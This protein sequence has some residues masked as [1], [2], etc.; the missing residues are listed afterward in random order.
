MCWLRLFQLVSQ[1][2]KIL[3]PPANRIFW[4]IKLSSSGLENKIRI[5]LVY[6]KT[7][8]SQNLA[9]MQHNHHW[10]GWGHTSLALELH[11]QNEVYKL[12]KRNGLLSR[13]K[14]S[15][16]KN[17]YLGCILRVYQYYNTCSQILWGQSGKM[18]ILCT[19]LISWQSHIWGEC[20]KSLFQGRDYLAIK[21]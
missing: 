18:R 16:E 19:M 3:V 11:P 13:G 7:P 21:N 4:Q 2:V 17:E 20:M 9:A 12:H 5:S 6:T 8:Q 15:S 14:V 10:W 1:P